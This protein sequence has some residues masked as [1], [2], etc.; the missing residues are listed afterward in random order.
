MSKFQNC[1]KYG[2][3]KLHGLPNAAFHYPRT[4]LYILGTCHKPRPST[5]PLQVTLSPPPP[6]IGGGGGE[7]NCNDKCNNKYNNAEDGKGLRGEADDGGESYYD[8]CD[9]VHVPSIRGVGWRMSTIGPHATALVNNDN[10]NNDRRCSGGHHAPP[11][12]SAPTPQ[13]LLVNVVNIVD[14]G[15]WRWHEGTRGVVVRAMEEE[16]VCTV[17]LSHQV[18]IQPGV[19]DGGRRS[20]ATLVGLHSRQHQAGEGGG[21]GAVP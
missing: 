7:Y 13:M 16:E 3:L 5:S 11:L 14:R 21:G 2:H 20:G 18:P 15:Q 8:G 6:L 4:A 10:D 1:S 12:W 9:V 17:V 19:D